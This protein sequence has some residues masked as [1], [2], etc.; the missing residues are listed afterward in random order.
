VAS[1]SDGQQNDN[2]SGG[3]LSAIATD[4]KYLYIHSPMHGLM[5]IGTGAGDSVRGALIAQNIAYRTGDSRRSIAFA[6]GKLLY[7]SPELSQPRADPRQ[8][9]VA[10]LNADTLQEEAV[11]VLP[12]PAEPDSNVIMSDG[13]QFYL[14]A[15]HINEKPSHASSDRDYRSNNKDREADDRFYVEVFNVSATNAVA[16]VRTV[17]LNRAP[18]NVSTGEKPI[19]GTQSYIFVP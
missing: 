14:L 11:I 17:T 7:T 18:V 1:F 2:N 12:F 8:A 13:Q 6:G 4:C 3:V 16:R 5:K 15:R 19:D 10:V 9:K